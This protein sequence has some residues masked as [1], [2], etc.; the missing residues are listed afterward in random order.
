MPGGGTPAVAEILGATGAPPPEEEV[1]REL[2]RIMVEDA[3][4]HGLAHL[5]LRPTSA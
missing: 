4:R 3:L 1:A 5:P 2:E